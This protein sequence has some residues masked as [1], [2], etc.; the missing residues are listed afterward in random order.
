MERGQSFMIKHYELTLSSIKIRKDPE[1]YPKQDLTPEHTKR[2]PTYRST[3]PD[4]SA[5]YDYVESILDTSDYYGEYL[6][7]GWAIREAFLAGVTYA[8]GRKKQ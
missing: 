6:W 5:A 8:E 1:D 4:V 3:H 2:L 7:H